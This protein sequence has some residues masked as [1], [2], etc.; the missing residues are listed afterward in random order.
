MKLR[1]NMDFCLNCGSPGPETCRC[2][3]DRP[4]KGRPLS[5]A[6]RESGPYRDGLILWS[7][8]G[9]VKGPEERQTLSEVNSGIMLATLAKW[10]K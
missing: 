5:P 6:A 10:R 8:S 1:L 2:G 9:L 4:K 7:R 3:K